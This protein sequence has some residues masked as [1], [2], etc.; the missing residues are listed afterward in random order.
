MAAN[1]PTGSLQP[2]CYGEWK[3]TGL[4]VVGKPED[5][6]GPTDDPLHR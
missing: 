4:E 2:C 6:C 3:T 5:Y 1:R